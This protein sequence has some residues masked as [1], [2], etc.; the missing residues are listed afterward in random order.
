MR[1][2]QPTGRLSGT[3]GVTSRI[4]LRG[5]CARAVLA[6]GAIRGGGRRFWRRADQRLS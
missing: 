6:Q 4:P 2:N 3:A 5:G 1:P